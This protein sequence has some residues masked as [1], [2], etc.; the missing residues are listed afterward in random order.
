MSDNL[1]PSN[2]LYRGELNGKPLEA[3]EAIVDEL[4]YEARFARSNYLGVSP[5]EED[6]KFAKDLEQQAQDVEG[7]RNYITQKI[8]AYYET[9][10]TEIIDQKLGGVFG[11]SIAESLRDGDWSRCAI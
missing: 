11:E 2:T 10:A 7:A 8:N 1:H 9:L 4:H 3:L 5:T 6:L